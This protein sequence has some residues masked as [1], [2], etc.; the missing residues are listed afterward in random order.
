LTVPPAG[1]FVAPA[2]T[3]AVVFKKTS[4]KMLFMVCIL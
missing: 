1:A 3:P 2:G 4:G